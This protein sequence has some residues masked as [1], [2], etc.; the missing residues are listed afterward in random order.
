MNTGINIEGINSLNLEISIIND[1]IANILSS[2][3][4]KVA[5]LDSFLIGAAN[6]EFNL[7]YDEIRRNY[8]VVKKNINLYSKDFIN[9]INKM[10]D[11]DTDSSKLFNSFTDDTKN[12]AKKIEI[13]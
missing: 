13:L 8:Y 5:Q 12:K 3:D 4:Q 1:E 2:I 9:L 7:K 10:K 6:R 11:V